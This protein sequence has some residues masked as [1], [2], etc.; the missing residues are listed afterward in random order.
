MP[1]QLYM[2]RHAQ[3]TNNALPDQRERVCD[4]PLTELGRR[5]AQILAE[6]LAA[7]FSP[8]LLS[9]ATAEAM[10]GRA[11]KEGYHVTRLFCSAMGRALETAQPIGAA[12]G[13]RP[14]V[15]LDIHERGGI[16]LDH[17]EEG[18]LVGY[19]GKTRSEILAEFPNYILPD[20]LT[21]E[22]WWRGS[23]EE[24]DASYGRAAKVARQ[25]QQWG[26]TSDD[27]RIALI[28]HGGFM[29]SLLKALCNQ[30][31]G[32]HLVYRHYNTAISRLDF[33]AD[34]RLGIVF[35]NRIGHLPAEL[36]T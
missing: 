15:W 31:P 26:P 29:D 3:S 33:Q 13:L 36:I 34:G 27:E 22:G 6:S 23:F 24:T 2:I 17:R 20:G 7:G 10:Q 21:E 11:K 4:P 9:L 12:L 19:P 1:L 25:L 30:L 28:S 35:L 18:G 5:Q 32:R 8:E 16:F 14:E